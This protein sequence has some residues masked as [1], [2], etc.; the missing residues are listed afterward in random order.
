MLGCLDK[1]IH[2][3]YAQELS[4]SD[5]ILFSNFQYV[6]LQA[7]VGWEWMRAHRLPHQPRPTT[8]CKCGRCWFTV[9]KA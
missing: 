8:T 3:V 6:C 1:A 2:I 7:L 9:W 4:Q 5:R